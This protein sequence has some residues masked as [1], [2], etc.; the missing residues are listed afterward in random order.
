MTNVEEFQGELDDIRSTVHHIDVVKQDKV[1]F[2]V[3]L[4][5]VIWAFTTTFSGV[6]WAATTSAQLQALQTVVES[7]TTD[8]YRGQQAAQDFALRDQ[9]I[10]F[11]QAQVD[12]LRNGFEKHNAEA[13]VWKRIIDSNSTKIKH[14][15]ETHA[16]EVRNGQ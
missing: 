12:Q 6:W 3:V 13:E 4:T 14:F 16:H 7:G 11:L 5:F 8:R 15:E 9:Q 1:K 10:Q 2:G